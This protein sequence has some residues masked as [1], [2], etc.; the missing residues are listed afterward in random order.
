MFCKACGAQLPENAKFC[1]DCGASIAPPRPVS[2]AD[3]ASRPVPRPATPSHPG[4]A[5][6]QPAPR[7][8][9]VPSAKAN[10][11]RPAGTRPPAAPGTRPAPAKSTAKPSPPKAQSAPKKKRG[12]ALLI[13]LI[14]LGILVVALLI[15][16][17]GMMV[18]SFFSKMFSPTDPNTPAA[19]GPAYVTTAPK[20]TE[21]EESEQTEPEDT[22][23]LSED[24]PYREY[25]HTDSRFI[26]SDSDK[27]YYSRAD[28]Q[29][30]DTQELAIA[31]AE[32][33]G[34][35][36]GKADD[37]YLQ[38]YLDNMS[39]YTAGG[40]AS[41][42]DYE[43]A[44]L[45]LM[46]VV[47]RELDGSLYRSDNPYAPMLGNVETNFLSGSDRR[48]LGASDMAAL[49]ADELVLARSEILARHGVL[50]QDKYL[51]EYFYCKLW[52]AP[53]TRQSDFNESALSDE[54]SCNI[55][56][57]ELYERLEAGIY[58]SPSNPYIPYYDR[59]SEYI[60]PAG[61]TKTLTEWDL[62]GYSLEELIIARNQII[63]LHGYSF[64]DE[65][66]LEYFLQCS[67]YQPSTAPGR[68]DLVALSTVESTNMNFINAYEKKLKA[69]PKLS[70]LDTALTLS[71]DT[72]YYTLKLPAYWDE[73][74]V[75]SNPN[76]IAGGVHAIGFYEKQSNAA[77][78]GGHLFTLNIL[79]E[80]QDYTY[81]PNYRFVCKFADETGAMWNIVATMPTDV[82]S[83]P[84]AAELY[85]H[86]CDRIPDILAT[87]QL[88]EGFTPV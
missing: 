2:A 57:I 6:R 3:Q 83:Q 49:D 51:Q 61:S 5:P 34:R 12:K 8:Q 85:G 74:A 39:W 41:L 19:D 78:G 81:L 28:I 71:V 40:S 27:R 46:D 36:G 58:P 60:L 68:S 18:Y 86:M 11:Q 38:E 32:I 67:W 10:P 35:H 31:A 13:V 37:K 65:E 79:P 14:I 50:F 66:L 53:T 70:N 43:K 23:P 44:N 29:D 80:S 22:N 7:P 9:T 33:P 17:V 48:Y 24:N 4:N 82:Q 64:S 87:L 21:P 20:Q 75:Q 73:Y 76:A 26:L 47:Q 77:N 30:L 56:L 55:A 69:Q 63:A 88:K 45:Q 84:Y 42:N 52:Y 72:P 54:E 25:Y 1:Q 16:V 59:S 15:G 62:A